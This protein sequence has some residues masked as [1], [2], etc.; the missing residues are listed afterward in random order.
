M[1]NIELV[2]SESRVK[3][4]LPRDFGGIKRD[5]VVEFLKF[6]ECTQSGALIPQEKV[7]KI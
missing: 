2:V 5:E 1:N 7:K 6:V 4:S 3:V